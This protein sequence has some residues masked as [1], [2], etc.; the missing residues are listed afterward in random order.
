MTSSTK[1]GGAALII[2]SILLLVGN[3]LHPHA[4]YVTDPESFAQAI[5][6]N[7]VIWIPDHMLLLL[8]FPILMLGFLTLYGALKEK[9]ERI[10]ALPAVYVLGIST[11]FGILFSVTDGFVEVIL[12]QDYLAASAGAKQSAGMILDYSGVLS[13]HFVGVTFGALAVGLIAL[14]ASLIKAKL[15]NKVFAIVG[16][17]LGL[18]GVAGYIAGIFGPYW[19]ESP[20]FTP[21]AVVFT[22]WILVLGVFQYRGR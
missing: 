7:I 16:L 9:D 2:G 22:V 5:T 1:V 11:L 19:V 12:A 15:Y 20:V 13:L 17:A 8:G 18:F 10:Y 3:I 21:Y 4:G 6:D 14:G